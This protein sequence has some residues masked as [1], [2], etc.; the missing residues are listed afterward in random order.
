MVYFSIFRQPSMRAE[1]GLQGSSTPPKYFQG[2]ME[3]ANLCFHLL[4]AGV[5]WR[6]KNT[7]ERWLKLWSLMNSSVRITNLFSMWLTSTQPFLHSSSRLTFDKRHNPKLPLEEPSVTPRFYY[8]TKKFSHS[9][10]QQI[11][12]IYSPSRQQ[13]APNPPKPK[14]TDWTNCLH[15]STRPRRV[16][17]PRFI[18][19]GTTIGM[20]T[21][22]GGVRGKW[23]RV[24]DL[25]FFWSLGDCRS[26]LS[27]LLLYSCVQRDKL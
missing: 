9:N 25:F 12:N 23:D 24:L 3:S 5:V 27:T 15:W 19:I 4:I 7:D 20:A 8:D 10:Y 16:R 2:D 26:S 17:E 22:I 21:P 14:L 13:T 11:N 1:L 6:K 18:Y